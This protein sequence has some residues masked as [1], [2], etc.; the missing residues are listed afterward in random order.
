MWTKRRLIR[1]SSW[2]Q[3][4]NKLACWILPYGLV[5]PSKLLLQ[6]EKS[7]KT[8]NTAWICST[9]S[10]KIIKMYYFNDEIQ[11]E[12]C[13]LKKCTRCQQQFTSLAVF[14]ISATKEKVILAVIWMQYEQ[15]CREINSMEVL[16]VTSLTL[17]YRVRRKRCL[18][19]KKSIIL[20]GNENI[21]ESRS[22]SSAVAYMFLNRNEYFISRDSGE[23]R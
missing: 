16:E 13:L 6:K 2:R 3:T 20:L 23:S 19:G 14:L 18:Q 10:I 7:D 22:F 21:E 17:H 9:L 11:N 4:E 5:C 1:I 8:S 15:Q 12:N